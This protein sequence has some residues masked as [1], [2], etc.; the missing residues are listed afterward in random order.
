[1][2]LHDQRM[3]CLK[4]A[5]ELGGKPE[6][7][8]TAAQQLL[9]FVT[10]PPP[11]DVAIAASLQIDEATVSDS[12]APTEAVP[13]PIAACGTALVMPEGG[14]LADASVIAGEP[15]TAANET[16]VESA[17]SISASE[18]PEEA[19]SPSDP[20]VL[21]IEQPE[22]AA[23]V[24]TTDEAPAEAVSAD[25]PTQEIPE[26]ADMSATPS[27]VNGIDEAATPVN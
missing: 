20:S 15:E 16:A 7:I 5:F 17:P 2:D 4:M 14:E 1:M 6:A 24:E 10:A 18:T 13:D 27:D 11:P 25:E 8:L 26:A 3:Q 19:A 22:S 23:A 12:E 9:D 21:A